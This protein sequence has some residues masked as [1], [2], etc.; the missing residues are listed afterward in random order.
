MLAGLIMSVLIPLS[1]AFPSDIDTH[2][3]EDEY[4]AQELVTL[5]NKYR[6]S[7]GL[8]A[9]FL[10]KKLIGLAESHSA[11]MNSLGVLSHDNFNDRFKKSGA[12]SCIENV[13]WNFRTARD[14]F[15]AWKKSEGHNRN[16][17]ATGIR[18]AGISK[19]GEY[20]TF[21]SCD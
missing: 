2:K 11:E 20:V 17:M 16:M 10:D 6:T 14:Q 7:N 21:F 15:I 9:L 3:S 4:F 19:I 12:D 5:I 18:K 13:G 8:N 1:A